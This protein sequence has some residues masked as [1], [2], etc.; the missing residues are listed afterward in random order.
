MRTETLSRDPQEPRRGSPCFVVLTLTLVAL[1]A[2]SARADVIRTA[3]SV[4]FTGSINGSAGPVSVAATLWSDPA[5][6]NILNL[7]LQNT[8]TAATTARA[9]LLTSFYFGVYG[10]TSSGTAP[11]LT[12]VSGSGQVYRAVKNGPDV[13]GVWIPPSV[14]GSG[15]FTPY[16]SG[17]SNLMATA[18]GDFTWQ[19]KSGL[20]LAA[21]EPPL[22]FG[23]GT[24]GNSSLFPN[25]FNGNVVN[26]DDFG[27]F[28][29]D[30]SSQSLATVGL[31]VSGSA[32]FRFSGFGGYTTNQI[33]D[34]A[35]FGLGSKPDDIISVPEP[36]TCALALAGAAATL[37]LRIRRQS[38]NVRGAR[39]SPFALSGRGGGTRSAKP[40]QPRRA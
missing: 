29:G 17:L 27:I 16:A 32:L 22:N 20:A 24:V 13:P 25:S 10:G 36:R 3:T 35:V 34:H 31:L 11:G 18:S 30:A 8:S 4:T 23:I 15:T 19:F 38:A 7:L 33:P 21:S 9:G 39:E 26:G 28:T 37:G 12:Y 40:A 5:T 6:P 1:P 14:G 2:V